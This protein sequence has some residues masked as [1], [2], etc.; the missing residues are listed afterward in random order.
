MLTDLLTLNAKYIL[1]KLFIV[2][3]LYFNSEINCYD[4]FR[5]GYFNEYLPGSAYNSNASSRPNIPLMT[6]TNRYG[7][8]VSSTAYFGVNSPSFPQ[9]LI[10]D[11]QLGSHTYNNNG[12]KNTVTL[13][14]VSKRVNNYKSYME[15][16][17]NQGLGA[18]LQGDA[19]RET[20]RLNY[21]KKVAQLPQFPPA[22]TKTFPVYAA[23]KWNPSDFAIQD[24]EEY[25]IT[26]EPQSGAEYTAQTWTD[27]G[28]RVDADGYESY[29]DAMSNCY[30]ALGRCRSHL[31]KRKRHLSADWMQLVC[32]VGEFVRPVQEVY[33]G[34]E[35]ES[36]FLPI[37]ESRVQITQFTVG[38]KTKFIAKNSG[39]L[40]CFANDAHTL[41]WNNAGK[42]DVTITRLTWPPSSENYYTDLSFPACDSAYAVYKN[43]GNWSTAMG[44]N[45]NG[46]G[47]GWVRDDVLK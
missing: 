35:E 5:E 39:Q 30:V 12:L 23:V 9:N 13:E 42:I 40:I 27:G 22:P 19:Q 7:D 14:Y 32:S 24:N 10:E 36:R 29:Y 43:K 47:S 20:A 25:L 33:P 15:N 18:Y 8:G 34:F 2:F 46:G 38:K 37:D 4:G 11:V 21:L 44:C 1:N 6:D 3:I 28:L 31:K 45:P 41:Y 17:E 16:A 26:A